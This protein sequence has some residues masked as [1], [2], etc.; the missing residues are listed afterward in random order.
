MNTN[1]CYSKQIEEV[2]MLA[3]Y[4]KYDCS[5]KVIKTVIKTRTF[6]LSTLRFI[7]FHRR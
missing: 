7:M 2:V 3:A 4:R 5:A 1:T 6:G